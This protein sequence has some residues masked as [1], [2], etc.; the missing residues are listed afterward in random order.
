MRDAF[1]RSE[2]FLDLE[3]GDDHPVE[4]QKEIPTEKLGN[5]TQEELALLQRLLEKMNNKTNPSN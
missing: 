4:K 3:K 1:N 2:E 5:L